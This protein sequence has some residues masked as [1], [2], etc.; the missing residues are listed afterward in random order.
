MII[1]VKQ[2]HLHIIYYILALN[3][4]NLAANRVVYVAATGCV[5][6][7][8]YILSIILLKFFGR[9]VS[10]CGLFT[11]SA[12]FLLILLI[13]PRGMSIKEQFII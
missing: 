5:D 7:V 4:D 12:F 3:A 13:V 2:N 6:F 8:S 1:I 9:K 10:I 11:M